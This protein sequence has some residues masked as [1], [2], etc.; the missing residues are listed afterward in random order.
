MTDPVK[1]SE[2]GAAAAMFPPVEVVCPACNG[3]KSI[4]DP[5]CKLGVTKIA[6]PTCEGIGFFH[7]E[8][9]SREEHY[10]IMHLLLTR[11]QL[12]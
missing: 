9:D 7:R 2:L 1:E 6:C 4:I 10:Y 3:E 12:R 11:F 8:M 5:L